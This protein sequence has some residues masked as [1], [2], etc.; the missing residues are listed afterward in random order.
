MFY[1]RHIL[2]LRR[3]SFRTRLFKARVPDVKLG[4]Y[5]KTIS[6]YSEAW[7]KLFFHNY[8]Q[9]IPLVLR[10][11]FASF[12]IT[13]SWIC[14]SKHFFLFQRN[15]WPLPCLILIQQCVTDRVTDFSSIIL[16]ITSRDLV[17]TAIWNGLDS[18]RTYNTAVGQTPT[19]SKNVMP[20]K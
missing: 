9:I 11:T 13:F 12:H 4:Y 6:G 14:L 20:P 16:T 8:Y 10:G 19:P 15:F 2:D 18:K 17:P 1:F 7:V 5:L 3:F